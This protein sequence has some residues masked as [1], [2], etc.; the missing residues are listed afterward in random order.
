METSEQLTH[1]AIDAPDLAT[2]VG[3]AGP[4]LSLYLNTERAVEN[5]GSLAQQR[6]KTA[7]RDLEGRGVP[8]VLLDEIQR[9][10][11]EAHL[12]GECL[13]V[14]GGAE[15]ILHVEHGPAVG[16]QDEAMWSP[17]PRV[18]PIVR[19]RQSEPPYVVVLIDRTGADLF[20]IRRGSRELHAEVEGEHDELRKVGP[21]GWSQRRY[22]QRAEDS[23]EQNA[24]QV[25]EAVERLVVQVQP[26]FVAVAGDVRAV[27]LLRESLS[28]QVDEL[29]HVVEGERP[30]EGKGDP[31]PEEVHE[32][33]VRHVREGTRAVLARFEEERGQH[34]K[35][36]EG[37]EA[38][39]RALAMA[40]VAVLLCAD[41]GVDERTLW[42][43]HD[44]VHLASDRQDL[45]ALGV[46]APEEEPARDVLTRAALG[47]GAGIR[48][49][50]DGGELDEGVGALLRWS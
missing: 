28:K 10:V 47:T 39:T 31:I 16:P 30:W 4:F 9:L 40:Q 6:W 12:E 2:L 36:V 8:A 11:P 21:G 50:D 19:W 25:A 32:L 17:I 13:A 23:W 22:Q 48:V 38:T 46:E 42:F 18:L 7:R 1:G 34:D 49:V 29:V 41:E 27:G 20:G 37:V 14:I 45:E 3:G 33:V 15:R 26:A 43:G 44:P 24:E 5:A 35:A